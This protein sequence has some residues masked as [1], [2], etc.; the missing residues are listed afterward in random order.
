MNVNSPEDRRKHRRFRVKEGA[1][2]VLKG[3]EKKLGQ[4]TDISGGG[5]AFKYVSQ[6][7]SSEGPYVLDILLSGHDFH[8]KEIPVKAISDSEIEDE[9][10]FSQI[11]MRKLGVQ[12]LTLTGRHVSQLEDFIQNHTMDKWNSAFDFKI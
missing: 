11:E 4:I 5:L 1:F 9:I 12:F 2:A 10:P 7:Q 8:L 6:G 3:E